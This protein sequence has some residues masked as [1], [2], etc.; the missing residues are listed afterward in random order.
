MSLKAYIVQQFREII[1]YSLDNGL[2][3]N[4]TFIAERLYVYDTSNAD[5]KHLFSLCLLRSGRYLTVLYMTEGVKHVGCAYIYALACLQLGKCKQGIAAL[6]AVSSQWTKSN[7]MY[8]HDDLYRSHLPDAAAIFCLLG[9]LSKKCGMMKKATDYYICSVKLNPF[10]WEA[11][12][13][14]CALGCNLHVKNIFK[15]TAGMQ[16]ARLKA[17][18]IP[19]QTNILKNMDSFMSQNIDTETQSANHTVQTPDIF[20]SQK[21]HTPPFSSHCQ[22]SSFLNRL[23][24]AETPGSPTAQQV[25]SPEI[26]HDT[27]I[28]LNQTKANPTIRGNI[29]KDLPKSST[30]ID[31]PQRRSQRHLPNASKI[32]SK[33]ASTTSSIRDSRKNKLQNIRSKQEENP[34][35]PATQVPS[36]NQSCFQYG[37]KPNGQT[38]MSLVERIEAETCLLDLCKSIADGCH[39]LAKYDGAKAIECFKSLQPASQRNSVF[40]LSKIGRAYFEMVNYDEAEKYFY[41]LRKA[42][43]TRVEDME[44]YSTVL[45]HLRKEVE[46]SFLAHEILDLDRLAPQSWCIIANCFSLQ[47]EHDQALKCIRR[48]IQLNPNFAYAYTLE[49]HEYG[50]GMVFLRVGKNDLAMYHFRKAAEINPTNAVLLC[51]IGMIVERNKDF[52]EALQLYKK[53]SELAPT[54]ALARFKKAKVLVCL[55]QYH[56]A[57]KELLF[58]KDLAPDE[59]NVHFLL[60]K[61]YKQLGDKPSAMRHLTVA[62]NLDNR[63]SHLIKEAI[64]SIDEPEENLLGETGEVY[65]NLDR[66]D[67]W[68]VA[69]ICNTISAPALNLKMQV[70]NEHFMRVRPCVFVSNHQS[71]L[72]ILLLGRLFPKYCSIVSKKSLKYVPFLGWFMILSK[73]IFID[74]AEQKNSIRTFEKVSREI[75]ANKQSVW[76]FV[77]GTRSGFKSPDLLPFKKGAFHLAIQAKI[78]IVPIVIQNYSRIYHFKSRIFQ[79]GI[80]KVKVLDP[81][82]TAFFSKSDVNQI[83]LETREKMLQTIIELN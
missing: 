67:Q 34:Q 31:I 22:Q 15:A 60:G 69:R 55:R 33:L 12:D 43:P 64:E 70:E 72:D 50:I 28:R 1:W 80:I 44:I 66:E 23:E 40:V 52:P 78:P 57:L 53:A 48:A 77:E 35:C 14:L 30:P 46:L 65:K 16:A 41:R 49:G 21:N 29:D 25:G 39:A 73:T 74:R 76:I 13:G 81:I 71:E 62:L 8:Q 7:S 59:A 4:A 9:H 58:L 32:A 75:K 38:V 83:A 17:Q 18:N 54:S 63:A 82:D 20:N 5:A 51:C 42:D 37:Q 79:S 56:L 6:E 19:V 45:W 27:K 36:S 47:R 68:G 24:T 3:S 11:F 2:L 26:T 61:L 10:L